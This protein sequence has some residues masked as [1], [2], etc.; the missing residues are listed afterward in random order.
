MIISSPLTF[1]NI[2]IHYRISTNHR[3]NK[4]IYW[5][6]DV[7]FSAA[8]IVQNEFHLN[9]FEYF[10]NKNWFSKNKI[11]NHDIREMFNHLFYIQS[12]PISCCIPMS[13]SEILVVN[14]GFFQ[15]V[16]VF[17]DLRVLASEFHPN[18]QGRIKVFRTFWSIS[19]EHDRQ[20]FEICWGPGTCHFDSATGVLIFR[21]TF[22]STCL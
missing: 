8:I 10:V 21:S 1:S 17:W 14:G 9:F 7:L 11:A 22:V 3:M 12:D 20:S 5:L 15:R 18:V 4:W 6:N 19:V 16:G 2:H 13:S